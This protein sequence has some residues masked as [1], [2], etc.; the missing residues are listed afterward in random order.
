V[1]ALPLLLILALAACGGDDEQPVQSAPPTATPT[2]TATAPAGVA[3]KR[4]TRITARDS[5]FGRMLWGP[6][7]QAIYIF[8]RDARG[9]SRCYGTCAEAWPPVYT[10]GKPVAGR[11]VRASLLGTTRRRN[12]RRQV[13]YAGKP[14]YYYSHEGP[15]EVLCHDVNLNGGFWWVV[16][17]D[18]KRRP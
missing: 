10:N 9:R 11:G 3:P 14:L 5:E 17:A 12:G 4:G 8:E 15:G 16:G 6:K 13:T 18:G 7:R 2:A 1:K